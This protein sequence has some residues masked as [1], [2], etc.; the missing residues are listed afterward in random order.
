MSVSNVNV[1]L[2]LFI[3]FMHLYVLCFDRSRKRLDQ[4]ANY[5]GSLTP[6][7]PKNRSKEKVWVS[8]FSYMLMY[9]LFVSV[10]EQRFSN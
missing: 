9:L 6:P 2:S 10:F 3:A 7:T 1:F 8:K 5:G 4:G